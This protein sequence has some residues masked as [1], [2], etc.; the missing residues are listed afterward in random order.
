MFD[1]SEEAAS[2][3]DAFLCRFVTGGA[4]SDEFLC[5]AELVTASVFAGF[6]VDFGAT[7][8]AEAVMELV[9]RRLP[10]TLLGG[11]VSDM[12]AIC[13]KMFLSQ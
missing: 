1:A 10:V 11:W 12:F 4:G 8:A 2:P 3:D 7:G 13:R 6:C 9:R 5:V